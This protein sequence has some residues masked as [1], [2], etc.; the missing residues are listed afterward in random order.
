MSLK[1]TYFHA[2]LNKDGKHFCLL[3]VCTLF[4][5]IVVERVT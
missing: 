3:G 2:T 4:Q 5:C 1:V